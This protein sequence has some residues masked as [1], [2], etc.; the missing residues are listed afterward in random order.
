MGVSGLAI[1]SSDEV[2]IYVPNS[3]RDIAKK[4][5]EEK[6]KKFCTKKKKRQKGKEIASEEYNRDKIAKRI[7]CT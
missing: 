2:Y 7:L 1:D 6:R 5:K 4:K 3:S